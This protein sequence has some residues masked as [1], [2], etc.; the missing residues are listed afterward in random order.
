M[1]ECTL[2]GTARAVSVVTWAG[3]LGAPRR[4]VAQDIATYLFFGSVPESRRKAHI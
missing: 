1:A 2:T 4:M 3:K